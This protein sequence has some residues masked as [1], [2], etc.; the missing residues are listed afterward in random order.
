M[1]RNDTINALN[2]C[3]LDKKMLIMNNDF[4]ANKT[5]IKERANGGSYFKD[6]Y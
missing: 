2:N 3:R 5:P 6:I 1:T 4:G